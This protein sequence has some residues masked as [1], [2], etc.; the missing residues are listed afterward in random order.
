[1]IRTL[2]ISRQAMREMLF[3]IHPTAVNPMKIGGAVIPN[4]VVLAVL[5]FIFVY[6]MTIVTTTFLL[7]ASGL[8]FISAFSGIIACINN[9][10]PGLN[11][12]GPA[13]NYASL[14]DFQ[15]WV[16]SLA[17]FLGRIEVFSLLILFTPAFW[18]K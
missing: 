11:K 3:L 1:M 8:D 9:A 12:V 17:M 16:C 13:T 2:I 4:K 14:S 7:M 5:G 10:G 6:F 15:T 18:R